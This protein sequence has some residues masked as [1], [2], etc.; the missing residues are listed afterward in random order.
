MTSFLPRRI[1]TERVYSGSSGRTIN[2]ALCQDKWSILYLVNLGCIELNPWLSRRGQ[3]E[4]PDFVVIDLDP[5]DNDF[6][7]VVKVAR[8]VHAL[9]ESIGAKSYCKTSGSTGLHIC[10]PTG[11]KFPYE[12]CRLFAEAVCRAIHEKFPK[13]TSVERNP[14]R[15]RGL[16][17]LDFLQ[18]RRGQ[19]LAA[20][21]CV[22]PRPG[23]PVSAPL[24]WT[25]VT[26]KLRPEHFT[27]EN[28][29]KRLAKLGDLW[30]PLLTE[31][32]DIEACHK[33]LSKRRHD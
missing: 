4:S 3:L 26:P 10:V 21:Y 19:T 6:R 33:R 16:I 31:S 13:T 18:N 2:Y 32:V 14:A 7:E 8:A 5:D 28:L 15:R 20:P 25:E 12:A 29:P 27:I 23:A 11:A 17:Y 24:K 1:Q 30:K 9:L 22:R